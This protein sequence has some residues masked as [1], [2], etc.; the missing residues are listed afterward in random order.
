V[1]SA[2]EVQQV[3]SEI[4]HIYYFKDRVI[5]DVSLDV[6][7]PYW[8]T[9]SYKIIAKER[10]RGEWRVDITSADGEVL[11]RLYFEIK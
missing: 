3:P 6:R 7:S 9:W 4:R 10:Y 5:S 1:W 11:R 2:I 8:R